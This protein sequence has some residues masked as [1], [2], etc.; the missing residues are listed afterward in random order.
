MKIQNP[1]IYIGKIIKVYFLDKSKPIIGEYDG[2]TPEYDDPENR[3]NIG[4]TLVGETTW[5]YELY[6]DEI[7]RIEILGNRK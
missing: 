2:Y 3:A 5:G 4:V 7:E 6:E 1:D